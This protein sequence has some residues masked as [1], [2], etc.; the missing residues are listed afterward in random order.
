MLAYECCTLGARIRRG[1]RWAAQKGYWTG[2]NPPYG[3]RRLL[4][5]ERGNPLHLLEPGQRKLIQ[6]QHVTLVA[7]EPAEVAAI[8]RIFREFVDLGH[9]TARIAE[10]LKARRIPS[11]SGGRWDAGCVRACLRTKA[12][13]GRLIYRRKRA[14]GKTADGWVRTPESSEGIISRELFE[15]AQ[16]ILAGPRTPPLA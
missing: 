10:G 2:G 8:R 6:K 16:K 12:Y 15:R 13:A 4:L 7:G 14:R 1:R 9:S 11:P 3:L 5:D